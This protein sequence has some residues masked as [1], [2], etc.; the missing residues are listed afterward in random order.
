MLGFHGENFRT[1]SL[2]HCSG[3]PTQYPVITYKGKESNKKKGY[4]HTC[5]RI[6]WAE[7]PGGLQSIASRRAGRDWSN[8]AHTCGGGCLVGKSCLT[9]VTPW[10]V[11]PRL[12]CP[13]D[14]P[15]KNTG[16]GCHFLP[17]ISYIYIYIYMYV[18]YTHTHITVLYTLN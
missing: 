5:V 10:T 17:H 14:F 9:L 12:V 4:T 11:A 18:L 15:G 7:E 3:N 8:L 6:P 13:W 2:P 16:E 1:E